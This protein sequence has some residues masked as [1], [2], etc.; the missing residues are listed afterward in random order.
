MK[1]SLIYRIKEAHRH[2]VIEGVICAVPK[3]VRPSEHRFKYRL[4]YLVDGKR[5]VGYGLR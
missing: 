1:A 3:P 5:V 2:G 4:V